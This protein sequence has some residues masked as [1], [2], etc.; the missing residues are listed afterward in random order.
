LENRRRPSRRKVEWLVAARCG[1]GVMVIAA[2]PAQPT[3]N[4]A[5][6]DDSAIVERLVR[7]D[8]AAL[9]E[10]YDRYGRAVYSFSL[11]MLGDVQSAEELTQEVF[12]KLWRQAQSYQQSRGAFLTWLLSITHN[13]A[14][15]EI[16]RRKRRPLVLDGQDED[17]P[18]LILPDT[19]TDVEHSAWLTTLQSYVRDALAEIP[20]AQ[21]QAIELAYFGGLTQREIAERLGEPLGTVKTRMRLGMLKLRDLLG[22][23][24]DLPDVRPPAGDNRD[25]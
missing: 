16:R 13:M 7:G 23:L 22:P 21:R 19:R 6:S 4:A 24:V 5:A 1:F 18:L 3:L 11:R 17:G 12:V 2:R 10:L 8:G 9:E 25:R 20:A 14:I 15:D